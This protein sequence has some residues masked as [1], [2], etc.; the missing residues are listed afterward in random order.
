MVHLISLHH[1]SSSTI[2]CETQLWAAPS[3]ESFCGAQTHSTSVH[4]L[5]SL[6]SSVQREARQTNRGPMWH[7]HTAKRSY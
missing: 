3:K 2:D 5:D 1:S 4:S 6:G 7:T